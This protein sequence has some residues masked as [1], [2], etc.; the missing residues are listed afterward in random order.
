M[1]AAQA[2][3][4]CFTLNNYTPEDVAHIES[5]YLNADN[6]ITYLVIGREVGDSGTPHLQ[7]FICFSRR[8][9][10]N[11]VKALINERIHIEG[12][13]GTSDQ[14]ATYCKKDGAYTEFGTVPVSGKT[15]YLE[16]FFKWADQFHEDNGRIPTARDVA[17]EHPVV[18]TRHRN[19]LDVLESRA[20][21]PSLVTNPQSRPWQL[22]LEEHLTDDTPDDR[23]V[24][25]FVDEE[26]GKGKS[27][28]QRHMLTKYPD[29]V[30]MLAPGKRDD[31]AHTIDIQKSIFLMNVPKTQMEFL[32]YSI[33]EQLKDR[34]VFSPKY[35][36]KM[37]VL[38]A[39]AHVIVF[40][41]EHPDMNKMSADRYHI[42]ILD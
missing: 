27:W 17:L 23:T 22:E 32:Q 37:K 9:T 40:S 18:L 6:H 26:G 19:V 12:A 35:T 31:L 10:F 15:N 33:L 11:V 16:D 2:R 21:P 1:P 4:F 29:R 38:S 24:E 8:K 28:F 36:S 42:T 14:A 30:Q 41:N 20:P 13:R 25:F 39:P 3:R 7:G 5:L 34:T